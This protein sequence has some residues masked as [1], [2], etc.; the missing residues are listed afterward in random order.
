MAQKSIAF[1][2]WSRLNVAIPQDILKSQI[3]AYSLAIAQ[4]TENQS[5]F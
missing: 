2:S 4:N 5:S 1:V 3:L